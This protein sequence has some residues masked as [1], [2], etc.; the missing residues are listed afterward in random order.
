[1]T[2][3]MHVSDA[4]ISLTKQCESCRLSAYQDLR[5]I[6]TIGY[7]HTGPDVHAGMVITQQEADALLAQDLEV[8]AEGVRRLVKVPL[9]QFQF[10]ALV[11]FAFNLGVGSLERSTLLR[12]LNEGKYLLAGGQ[13]P[14]WD[15]AG[16]K[17]V[18]GL[19]ARRDAE[20]RLFFTT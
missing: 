16:D 14:V 5:G 20:Q 2:Q 7:G 17:V 6:W 15:H 1:M 13:F 12:L 19:L 11:D 9:T 3:E 10:D 8:A 4:G 18:P